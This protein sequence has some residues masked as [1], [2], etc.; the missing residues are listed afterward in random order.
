MHHFKY[1]SGNYVSSFAP[2]PIGFITFG[3]VAFLPVLFIKQKFYT[4]TKE[5]FILTFLLIFFTLL[6]VFNIGVLRTLML[7]F[8]FWCMLFAIQLTKNNRVYENICSGYV[9]FCFL[10]YF[11]F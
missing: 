4:I 7:L 8:P 10:F 1:F 9:V 2:V 6:S 11:I 3:F 5:V